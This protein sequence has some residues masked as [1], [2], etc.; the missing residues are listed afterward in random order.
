MN[1][2]T[3]LFL[4]IITTAHQ[5]ITGAPIE[6]YVTDYSGLLIP[7]NPELFSLFQGIIESLSI[8]ISDG[9]VSTF[10]MVYDS[11]VFCMKFH[12]EFVFS[13]VN[14][15]LLANS[16]ND[17]P[18]STGEPNFFYSSHVK[19]LGYDWYAFIMLCQS[20]FQIKNLQ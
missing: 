4:K 16:L 12:D 10:L 8:L 20:H 18:H 9:K 11:I 7:K 3:N 17:L 5:H 19:H 6:E 1:T 2:I 15:K 13:G 14:T